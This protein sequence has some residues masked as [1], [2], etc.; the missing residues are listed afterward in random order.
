M[1]R[2]YESVLSENSFHLVIDLLNRTIRVHILV[3]TL[4][5][6][7][8]NDLQGLLVVG[9][10]AFFD[11]VDI[12]IRSTAGFPAFEEAVEHDLLTA[13]KMQNERNFHLIV[14]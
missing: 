1:K 5:I 8:L 14:H 9:T 4:L 7:V 3:L 6:I 10:E 2:S 12:V 11:A 13:D